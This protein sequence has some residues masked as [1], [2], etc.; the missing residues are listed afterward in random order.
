[1]AYSSFEKGD[2]RKAAPGNCQA[3]NF[4]LMLAVGS[5]DKV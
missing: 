5:K 4:I 1:M 2:C 3:V